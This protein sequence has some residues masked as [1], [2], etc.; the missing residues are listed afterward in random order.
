MVRQD[1][2]QYSDVTL[3]NPPIEAGIFLATSG[4]QEALSENL[5]AGGGLNIASRD[6]REQAL[7]AHSK[8]SR[9]PALRHLPALH[10]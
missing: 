4:G 9:A 8:A 5:A 10:R 6:R 3:S 7:F 1:E 2:G